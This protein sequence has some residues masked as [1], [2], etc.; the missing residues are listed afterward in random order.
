MISAT[1]WTKNVLDAFSLVPSVG[2]L[3]VA[4]FI[5]CMYFSALLSSD[6]I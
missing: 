1:A 5:A 2:K 6:T 3:S 4:A